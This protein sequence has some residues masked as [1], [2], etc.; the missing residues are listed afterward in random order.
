MPAMTRM[1]AT[2]NKS[3]RI[4]PLP[5]PLSP[6]GRGENERIVVVGVDHV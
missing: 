3:L 4:F 1:E 6:K 2:M 5:R